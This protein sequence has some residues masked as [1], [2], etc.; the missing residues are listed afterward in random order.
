MNAAAYGLALAKASK[1]AKPA[2]GVIKASDVVDDVAVV[3]GS[4]DDADRRIEDRSCRVKR[5]DE[6]ANA[7]EADP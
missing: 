3:R 4:R 1:A 5:G 7:A 6:N 2:A